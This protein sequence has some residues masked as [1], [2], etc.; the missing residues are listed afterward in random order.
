MKDWLGWDYKL[1]DY[2]KDIYKNQKNIIELQK[3]NL[4]NKKDLAKAQKAND[5]A[6]VKKAE[7]AIIKNAEERASIEVSNFN[8]SKHSNNRQENLA[9]II[10]TPPKTASD[11]DKIRDARE[12][13]AEHS[14]LVS[15]HENQIKVALA[16]QKQEKKATYIEERSKLFN[17]S[18]DF[19]SNPA[20]LNNI[21]TPL[22]EKKGIKESAGL[23][24][25]ISAGV[26][27][28]AFAADNAGAIV[29]IVGSISFY[30]EEA[31]KISRGREDK[32]EMSFF[33]KLLEDPITEKFLSNNSTKLGNLV[34]SIAPNI[35]SIG[36]R[37]LSKLP[38][39]QAWLK[40]DRKEQGELPVIVEQLK[41]LE[42]K[43]KLTEADKK[44]IA[45]LKDQISERKVLELRISVAETVGALDKIGVNTPYIAQKILPIA[46]NPIKEILKNPK[47]IIDV[48][49]ASLDIVLNDDPKKTQESLRLIASK[50]DV[51][52]LIG[53][54]GLQKF[55]R[56]EGPKLGQIAA[57]VM[58]NNP[59]VK[60]QT[61]KFG[62]TPELAQN[63][64]PAVT[65]IASV[66]LADSGKLTEVYNEVVGTAGTLADINNQR[67]AQRK[68]DRS[69]LTEDEIK[70]LNDQNKV[71]KNQRN[72]A[73]SALIGSVTKVA[74]EDKLLDSIRSTV[75]VLLEQNQ[76]AIVSMV[77]TNLSAIEKETLKRATARLEPNA[78]LE[79]LKK[80]NIVGQ[81]ITG[82]SPEFT[83]SAA[84]VAIGLASTVLKE[85][86]NKQIQDLVSSGQSFLTASKED[87]PKI[88]QGIV[89]QG[90]EILSNP[91]IVQSVAKVGG[92][93]TT[94]KD[95]VQK[96]V[97]NVLETKQVKKQ[98]DKF[99]VAPELVQSVVPLATQ[100]GA[101]LLTEENLK[102]IPDAYQ[103]FDAFAKS[104]SLEAAA[105]KAQKG[106]DPST[107]SEE[108][109]KQNEALKAQS[110]KALAGLVGAATDIV[111]QKEVL[112]S[113][114][115]NVTNLLDN[116][117]A[118]ISAAVT[119]NINGLKDDSL[120][121]LAL[122]GVN[123]KFIPNTVNAVTGL[124]ST[125][126]KETSNAQIQGL[127]ASGQAFLTASKDDRPQVIQDLVSQGAA[128]LGNP[129]IAGSLAAVGTTLVNSN[130]DITKA[131]NNVVENTKI[132]EQV[133]GFGIT[134]EQIKDVV[135]MA[136]KA[137]SAVLNSAQDIANIATRSGELLSSLDK[138]TQGFTPKQA[139]SVGMIVD[140]LNKIVSQPGI[141]D[142]LSQ[143][144]PAF[145]IK[146]KD[147]IP[148][149]ASN[150]VKNTPALAELTGK[151]EIPDSLIR[152]TAKLGTD[153]LIG[154]APMVDKLA[155]ATLKEKDQLVTIISDVRDLANMPK[156]TS[157]DTQEKAVLKVVSNVIALKNNNPELKSVFDNELP[158]LLENNKAQLA[159][160]IDGVIATKAGPGLK[161]ET[162]KIIS[163]AAKNL[164]A[165]TE[166]ADLYSKGS[167]AAM[168]PKIVKLAFQKDVLST[169]IS[170]FSAVRKF[171]DEGKKDVKFADV[172]EATVKP[173][174]VKT[175]QLELPSGDKKTELQGHVG[176]IAED[177]GPH[178]VV[179]SKVAKKDKE[180]DMEHIQKKMK[181]HVIASGKAG[182]H[183]PISPEKHKELKTQDQGKQ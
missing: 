8:L 49:N 145:L 123:D 127:A 3:E 134:E 63:V 10:K 144:L 80:P 135:P 174:I 108:Q 179:T 76:G 36:I 163:I 15:D 22:A 32:E 170:T 154:A 101:A 82:V 47:D 27:V 111:L 155:K 13:I 176:K 138:T 61:E 78:D 115:T 159:K 116:N 178:V 180:H 77:T 53:S 83:Q 68:I 152:D 72:E 86:S 70:T 182:Q 35:I 93:L 1:S 66:A 162:E 89:G 142:T 99:G 100:V 37:E 42:A 64:I 7:A 169:A 69:T 91:N 164:P 147:A 102:K 136:T 25:M 168:F 133:K 31:A 128:I 177:L 71:L 173:E 28:I 140:S 117:Q 6:G 85:T 90:V 94:E 107:L 137:V 166:L 153:L 14:K 132:G 172:L 60:A 51:G 171:K 149:I 20:S 141:S 112:E 121:K 156:G 183:V 88:I 125:V 130:A 110:N 139:G 160:V 103:A 157:K 48:A 126:L 151:M 57:V 24:D 118:A 96:V 65:Q 131:V 146:N 109:V 12:E 165:V 73:I 113:V 52:R 45:E 34:E 29:N 95:Q 143:D 105:K 122:A 59:F 9:A 150:I 81:I 87:K 56:Q 18:S 17:A 67:K 39:L 124:V 120:P 62:L 44:Q 2:Q 43:T 19:I 46:I 26:S 79:S 41:V 58:T 33:I 50:V 38:E 40:E 129:A 181:S 23:G 98:L 11:R 92:L 21:L 75:P 104:S 54:S 114:R 175:V 30:K 158:G 84:T 106:I 4:E 16:K 74:L 161:L 55:L 119:H 97:N 5:R 148:D 167:Y